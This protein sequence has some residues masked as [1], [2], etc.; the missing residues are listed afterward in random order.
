MTERELHSQVMRKLAPEA[1]GLRLG[2]G[3][4]TR[5]LSKP[6]IVVETPAGDSHPCASDLVNLRNYVRD[7]ILEA[8]G[9]SAFYTCTDICDGVHPATGP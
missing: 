2:C 1:D 7:G 5:D 9:S 3:W 8:G 6:W 4:H